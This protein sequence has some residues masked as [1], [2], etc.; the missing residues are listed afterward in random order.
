VHSLVCVCERFGETVAVCVYTDDGVAD[1]PS[2]LRCTDHQCRV[3]SV[4]PGADWINHKVG[5]EK[6]EK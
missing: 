3:A 6:N 2:V 4:F 5:L 1:W